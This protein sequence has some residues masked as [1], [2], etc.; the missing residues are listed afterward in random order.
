MHLQLHENKRPEMAAFAVPEGMGCE[1]AFCGRSVARCEETTL[2]SRS[3]DTWLRCV[4]DRN[5]L[6]RRTMIWTQQACSI[7]FVL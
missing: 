4:D 5:S 2:D 7:D 1:T 6:R 3:K